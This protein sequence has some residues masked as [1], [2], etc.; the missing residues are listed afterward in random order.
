MGCSSFCCAVLINRPAKKR[1]KWCTGRNHIVYFPT[2]LLYYLPNM[3]CVHVY[4]HIALN[5]RGFLIS[6][7]SRIF[8]HSR[9]YFNEN[10]RHT[11][12]FLHS[13]CKSVIG[14]HPGA[15]AAKSARNSLQ[16]DTC[17]LLTA[18][19]LSGRQCDRMVLVR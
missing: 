13:D 16:G 6:Q 12:Q 7:I 9:K 8:N 2:L 5:F 1:G 3:V 18:V 15:Y 11:T 17:I 19:S 14:Q 4:Y 10:F